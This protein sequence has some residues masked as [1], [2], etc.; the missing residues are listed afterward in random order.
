MC[1]ILGEAMTG[2]VTAFGLAAALLSTSAEAATKTHPRWMIG[3]WAWVS[4]TQTL[5]SGDCP[6]SEFYGRNGYVTDGES[7][8]RWWIEGDYLVRVTV[9]P[10]YGEPISEAGR[11][12]RQHF[13]R[14]RR[15]TLVF[16]GDA[17]VQWLVRCGDVPPEWEYQPKRQ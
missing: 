16:R 12:Y 17:Y 11:V 8:S 1:A 5:R 9:E 7:I 4:P 6:E 3:Q 10:G 14:T 15:D 2:I 13:T